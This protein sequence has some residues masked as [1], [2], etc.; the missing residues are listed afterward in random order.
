M[1]FIELL[2]VLMVIMSMVL[3]VDFSSI[4]TL[5]GALVGAGLILVALHYLFQ[6]TL[7]A[8]DGKIFGQREFK[9]SSRRRIMKSKGT[10]SRKEE[11]LD[12]LSDDELRQWSNKH[13][14]DA[15][16]SE[17]LCERYKK[18]GLWP[19]YAREMEYLLTLESQMTIEEKCSVWQR[20]ADL[21]QHQLARPDKAQEMLQQLIRT[22]PKNYQATLARRRLAEMRS[23][24][25]GRAT[26][27]SPYDEANEAIQDEST[28]RRWRS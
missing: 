13:P 19:N 7:A 8:L 3:G 11:S 23:R 15:D 6:S 25:E 18:A 2:I 16:A 21:Y 26:P 12:E 9:L 22:Y 27:R 5:A 1:M 20:L 14:K 24:P 10:R 17:I 4:W 28:R